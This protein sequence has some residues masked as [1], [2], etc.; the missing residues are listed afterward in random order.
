MYDR[1]T[2]FVVQDRKLTV[3][4]IQERFDVF[5]DSSITNNGYAVHEEL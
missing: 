1:H 5:V 4:E 3:E 2:I